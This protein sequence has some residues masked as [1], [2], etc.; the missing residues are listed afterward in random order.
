MV[1]YIDAPGGQKIVVRSPQEQERFDREGAIVRSALGD[2]AFDAAFA[3]GGAMTIEQAIDFAVGPP[4][5]ERP[6]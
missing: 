6:L 2:A 1:L 3:E 5:S 4:A